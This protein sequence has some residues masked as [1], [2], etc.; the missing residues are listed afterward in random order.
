MGLLAVNHADTLHV[1]MVCKKKDVREEE[2]LLVGDD[3]VQF[4]PDMAPDIHKVC[5]EMCEQ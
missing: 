5:K 4:C 2:I 1:A 3:Q